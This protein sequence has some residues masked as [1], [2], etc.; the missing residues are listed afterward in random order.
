MSLIQN[1]ELQKQDRNKIL[2]NYYE[3]T[4]NSL[5]KLYFKVLF[6]RGRDTER[7]LI[8]NYPLFQIKPI[9]KLLCTYYVLSMYLLR[10]FYIPIKKLDI[11]I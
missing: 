10:K 2:L 9:L 7:P 5:K 3:L 1:Y 4:T 6:D 11:M 8:T